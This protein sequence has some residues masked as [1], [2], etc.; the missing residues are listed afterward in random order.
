M[1]RKRLNNSLPVFHT[2]LTAGLQAAG[3]FRRL[4]NLA[5]E[6]QVIFLPGA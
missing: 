4:P 6:K 3:Q 5:G 1:R 2:Q